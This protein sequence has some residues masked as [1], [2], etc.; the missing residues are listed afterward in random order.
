MKKILSVF[1]ILLLLIAA[2]AA[3]GAL[4]LKKLGSPVSTG[5]Q[6]KLRV[7]IPGGMSVSE[8]GAKLFEAGLIRNKK[9]L[10]LEA[11]F[12]ISVLL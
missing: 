12:I 1:L 8:A 5:E 2:V 11:A 10:C 9:L 6:E 7:E 3:A 4:T